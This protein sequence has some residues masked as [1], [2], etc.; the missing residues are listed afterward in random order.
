ME[1]VRAVAVVLRIADGVVV[2]EFFG[3]DDIVGAEVGYR[4]EKKDEF[5]DG[6][7]GVVGAIVIIIEVVEEFI[8]EHITQ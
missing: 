2:P 8:N 5:M 7:G 3:S 4:E 6:A 1:E